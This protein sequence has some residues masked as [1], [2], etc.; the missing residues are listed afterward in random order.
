MYNCNYCNK[1]FTKKS[2][3][4]K[5]I[6]TAKYCLKLQEQKQ[7]QYAKLTCTYCNKVLSRIDSLQ[8]HYLTCMDYSLHTRTENYERQI[9][10]L[11]ERLRQRELELEETQRKLWELTNIS[12][13]K[14]ST[15]IDVVNVN[16]PEEIKMAAKYPYEEINDKLLDF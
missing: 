12:V 16:K 13:N 11:R 10:D 8:R 3:L 15:H 6:K 7:S 14:V 5:H 1:Q 2:N 9:N 4:N